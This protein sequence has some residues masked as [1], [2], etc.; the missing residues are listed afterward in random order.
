MTVTITPPIKEITARFTKAQAN[1]A[2]ERQAAVVYL[3][4]KWVQLAREEAP[5]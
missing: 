5:E 3:S 4:K 2:K 1:T